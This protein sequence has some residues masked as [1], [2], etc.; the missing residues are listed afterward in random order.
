MKQRKTLKDVA[1]EAGISVGMASRVLGNY[2]YFSEES[3]AKVLKAAEK[4][5]YK[6]DVI[7]R[8]LKTRQTKAIGVVVSDVLT[9]FFTTLV[10]GI[11]D[12]ASQSSYSVILKLI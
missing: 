1:R 3:K 2:G 7:A 5:S 12:V 4:L 10:R 6:P 8:G 9:F 11:E